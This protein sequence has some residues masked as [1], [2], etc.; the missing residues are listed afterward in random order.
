MPY[1]PDDLVTER[2]MTLPVAASSL[3]FLLGLAYYALRSFEGL[4]GQVF[5]AGAWLLIAMVAAG[6]GLA[7]V[8]ALQ[9][10]GM[11][12]PTWWGGTAV[13]VLLGL[14]GA[15]VPTVIAALAVAAIETLEHWLSTRSV[16]EARRALRDQVQTSERLTVALGKLETRL[17]A[18][19]EEIVGLAEEDAGRLLLGADA[20]TVERAIVVL[21][22]LSRMV[23]SDPDAPGEPAPGTIVTGGLLVW[24][25]IAAFRH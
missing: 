19:R 16:R 5:R 9:A 20:A 1:L 11:A 6:E 25:K 21:G 18:V 23:E 13:A 17:K 2:T 8:G 10:S 7:V 14:S 22:R 24:D 3:A 4:G 15:L 12:T